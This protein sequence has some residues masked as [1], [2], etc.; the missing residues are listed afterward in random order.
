MGGGRV[1]KW[2]EE[3]RRVDEGVAWGKKKSQIGKGSDCVARKKGKMDYG[4]YGHF[5][6]GILLQNC[7]TITHQLKIHSNFKKSE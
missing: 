4:N 1:E 2:V 5:Q 3:A 7:K 6:Q